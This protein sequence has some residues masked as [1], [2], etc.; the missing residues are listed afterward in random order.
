[1]LSYFFQ[2]LFLHNEDFVERKVKR[3]LQRD[4]YIFWFIHVTDIHNSKFHHSDI[5]KDL[6]KF[7]STTLDIV[8]PSV[9]LAS[10]DY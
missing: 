1:M 8:K 7:Y 2:S 10:G 5:K 3:G 6:K 9:V 4:K